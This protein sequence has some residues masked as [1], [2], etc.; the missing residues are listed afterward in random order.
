MQYNNRMIYDLILI[1]ENVK[2]QYQLTIRD[3]EG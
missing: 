1:A 3:L 2:T